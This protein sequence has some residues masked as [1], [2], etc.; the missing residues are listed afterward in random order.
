MQKQYVYIKLK[1]PNYAA[2]RSLVSPNMKCIIK[3]SG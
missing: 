2:N 3:F 1:Q